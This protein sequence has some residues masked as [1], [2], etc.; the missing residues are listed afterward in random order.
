MERKKIIQ[1]ITLNALILALYYVFSLPLGQLNYGIIN[2]RISEVFIL[3]AIFNK[4]FIPG[5]VGGCLLVNIFS[6]LPFDWLI[7]TGQTLIACLILY[8]IKNR[9]I[10]L[11]LAAL[12][13][14]VIIGV[15]LHFFVNEPLWLA[16]GSVLLSELII[17][18]I[19]YFIWKAALKNSAIQRLILE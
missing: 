14:G 11:F 8:F 15:E 16:M 10:S 4:K 2:I 7:G 17:L 3:L 18:T 5:L 1:T 9:Y 19:G 12:S 13:C 6:G